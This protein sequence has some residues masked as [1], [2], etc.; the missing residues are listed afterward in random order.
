[1]RETFDRRVV[2]DP[3]LEF[4]RACQRRVACH[5]A[6]GAALSGAF[7]S[8][9]LTH[10][11]DLFCHRAQDMRDLV[12]DLGT[13]AASAGMNVELAQDTPSFVRARLL[14]A[15]RELEL[16]IVHES[17]PD[18]EP[19]PSPVEGVTVESLADLRAAKLTCILSRSEPRDL[20]DLLFLDR[21]GYP[22]ERDLG[23]ALRKDAGIDPGVLAWLLGKFPVRP[24]PEMLEPLTESELERFRDDLC[25]RLRRAAVPEPGDSTPSASGSP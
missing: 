21:A 8:H 25:E 3:A 24:L 22:P 2:P 5:L 16:D 23:L 13:I 4:V 9:R 18:L 12:H 10:D 20:V 19:P 17:L 11:L 15:G 6:G 1:L 14:G 7:L